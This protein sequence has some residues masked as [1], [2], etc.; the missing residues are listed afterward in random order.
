MA[1]PAIK[2][3]YAVDKNKMG[4]IRALIGSYLVSGCRW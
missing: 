3:D 2:P 1:T 4:K